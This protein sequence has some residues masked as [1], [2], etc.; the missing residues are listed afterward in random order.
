MFVAVV[1]AVGALAFFYYQLQRGH[2]R[3]GI[4][5]ELAAIAKLKVD[6]ISEWHKE[7]L[8]DAENI[9]ANEFIA[10]AI[11]RFFGNGSER[12]SLRRWLRS[13]NKGNQYENIILLD[14][15][16]E[17]RI[18]LK[19]ET[20]FGPGAKKLIAEAQKTREIV[21]SDFY[22]ANGGGAI[23]QSIIVPIVSGAGGSS[24]LLAIIIL[25]L[26]LNNSMFPIIST[27]PISSRSA[28]SRLMRQEG[29]E[30]KYLNYRGEGNE[31]TIGAYFEKPF[32]L[33]SGRDD[34]AVFRTENRQGINLLAV[35]KAIPGTK[36]SLVSTV[37]AEEVYEPINQLFW[38]IILLSVGVLLLAAAGIGLI[39][40]HQ[41]AT[42]YRSQYEAELERVAILRNYEPLTRYA[43]DSIL[44]FDSSGNILEA[45]ERASAMLGYTLEE[46]LV[47]NIGKIGSSCALFDMAELSR[48]LTLSED[49][50][51]VFDSLYH[52]KDNTE[53]PVEVSL[54]AFDIEG[55]VFFQAIIRDITMRIK[56][57]EELKASHAHLRRLSAH[58]QS[59]TEEE[60][61]R[62]AR[63]VHDELGQVLTAL[64]METSWLA[65]RI[66]AE[67]K[68]LADKTSS[69][70][71]LIDSAIQS[72]KRICTELRPTLLDHL[73]ISAAIEWQAE[74]FRRRSGIECDLHLYAKNVDRNIGTVLFRVLQEALTNIARHSEATRVRVLLRKERDSVVMKIT[75][76][77]IGIKKEHI[78]KSR[79]FGIL[80]MRERVHG[81]GGRLTIR[82]FRGGG[83][84]ISIR[85]PIEQKLPKPVSG[86]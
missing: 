66:P 46:L 12:E 85:L 21:F 22:L 71:K 41:S 31:L 76:N 62:I 77:G 79:S 86:K 25:R 80:G 58:L 63:E 82:G 73:G 27:W 10:P 65:G 53:L 6:Q 47:M 2:I 1:V 78:Y 69:M 18:G 13:Y 81:L 5:K 84:S 11:T 38:T 44:L 50:G 61:T 34:A 74:E 16:G 42:Y 57:E 67:E 70:L 24:K 8:A 7:R 45:N 72:V 26:N 64:N 17:I 30:I 23:R 20:G 39:W 68:L 14:A 52:R 29:A 49:K 40:R 75:D 28:E 60:R 36:W 56:A 43:N 83:T 32:S 55:R 9:R 19:P 15:G 37:S 51:M 33:D 59:V 3:S 35:T 54:R 4:E 48:N